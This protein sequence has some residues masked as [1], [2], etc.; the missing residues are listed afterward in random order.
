VCFQL[1]NIYLI[2]LVKIKKNTLLIRSVIGIHP[3]DN[4]FINL[5]LAGPSL[6]KLAVLLIRW[7][8]S[9]LR[10]DAV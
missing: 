1:S 5:E 9:Y 8:L 3:C 6:Y 2:L 4:V 10:T 7:Y